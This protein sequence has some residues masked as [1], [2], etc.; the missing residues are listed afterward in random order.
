MNKLTVNRQNGNVPKTLAG[1]DHVSGLIFYTEKLP[2]GFT[3]EERIKTISTIDKAEELGITAESEDWAMRVMHYHLSE[4]FRVNSGIS[5]YVG[6]FAKSDTFSEV[7]TLQNYAD[8]RLR[9]IGIWAGDRTLS[10]DDLTAI[11]SVAEALDDENAPLSVLYSPK[12]ESVNSLPTDMAQAGLSRVSV[13]IAQAG[14]GTGAELYADADNSDKASVGLIGVAIGLLS[15]A[16]VHQAISWVGGFPTG[17]TM[18][19][20]GDGTLYRS[21]DKAMIEQLDAA[22]YLFLVTYPGIA[23]SYMNDSHTM[24]APTSDYAYIEAVRTMD[25]AIRGVRTN[26]LPELGGNVY[27]DADSGKLQSYSC[28]HLETVAGLALEDMKKAGEISDYSVG[29]DAEQDVLSSSTIEI[30]IK[31]V[32]AGV[33]RQIK[34]KIGYTKSL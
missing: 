18:P 4:A 7:K 9:Q 1:E 31:I 19:A 21:V 17:V 34:V 3:A 11:E 26:V 23:G 12:V 6:V 20:F 29:V 5:L 33:T 14:S 10:A 32:Q 30:V 28:A 13:L 15:S 22:G 27:I 2:S 16:Q 25:K 24:D 8:G